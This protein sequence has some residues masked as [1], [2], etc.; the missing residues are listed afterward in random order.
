VGTFEPGRA[1]DLQVIDTRLPYADLTG[2]G[3]FDAPEDRLARILYLAT[4]D[5]IRQVY[6]QGRRV[7]EK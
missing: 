5:N 3:V 4:P 1:F 7:I 6:V 2:F